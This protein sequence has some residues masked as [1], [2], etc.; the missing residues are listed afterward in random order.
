MDRA[1]R[2]AGRTDRQADQ[3]QGD[4]GSNLPEHARSLEALEIIAH[5]P[6]PARWRAR[7]HS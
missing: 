5:A 7:L 2:Q 4:E 6:S 1:R 3:C